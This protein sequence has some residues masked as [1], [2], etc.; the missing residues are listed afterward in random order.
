MKNAILGF[1]VIPR[2]FMG[3]NAVS[4]TKTIVFGAFKLI[5]CYLLRFF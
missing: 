4:A 5:I 1:K 3:T 2:S